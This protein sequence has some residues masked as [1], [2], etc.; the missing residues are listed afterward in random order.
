[1]LNGVAKGRV[2]RVENMGA[3]DLTF[4]WD[5]ILDLDEE[6]YWLDLLDGEGAIN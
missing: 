5:D 2:S 6:M 4:K 1:M 3:L